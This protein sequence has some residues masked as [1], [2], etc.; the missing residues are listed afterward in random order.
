MGV[1]VDGVLVA[2]LAVLV[3]RGG[4]LLGLVVLAVLVVVGRLVVVMGGRRVVGRGLVVV[5]DGRVLL[6]GHLRRLPGLWKLGGHRL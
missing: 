3:R 5:L 1:G 4:V 2:V 6:F